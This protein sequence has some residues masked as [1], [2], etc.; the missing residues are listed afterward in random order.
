MT[1]IAETVRRRNVSNNDKLTMF[2]T[3]EIETMQKTIDSARD[4]STTRTATMKSYYKEELNKWK[5]AKAD[6]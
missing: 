6:R 2:R 5:R 4:R 1:H 3:Q